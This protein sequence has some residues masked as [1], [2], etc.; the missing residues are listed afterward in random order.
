MNRIVFFGLGAEALLGSA[1]GALWGAGTALSKKIRKPGEVSWADV[2]ADA[3]D[4]A[5]G[6]AVS[7]TGVALGLAGLRRLRRR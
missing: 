7:G 2:K 5:V 4:N 6:G 3:F 1:G